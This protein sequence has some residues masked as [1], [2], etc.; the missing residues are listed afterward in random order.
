MNRDGKRLGANSRFA[1]EHVVA[2][3]IREANKIAK[4]D[5]PNEVTV[6]FLIT[7]ISLSFME[8]P[9]MPS[10]C[11]QQQQTFHTFRE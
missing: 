9:N 1:N 3:F 7:R 5:C 8:E 10:F 4:R 6:P 2:T 11:L